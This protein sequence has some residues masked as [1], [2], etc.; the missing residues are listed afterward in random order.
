MMRQLGLL[1]L[2]G[3]GTSGEPIKGDISYTYGSDS[4]KFS[5][6]TA[7]QDQNVPG[8]MLVQIGTDHVDC[9][10]YLDNFF[11][12][13]NPEGTFVFFSVDKVTPGTHATANVNV[14]K[15]SGS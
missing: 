8:Q 15:S 4:A 10:T 3:C 14:M 9:G 2:I 6:G 11:S 5:V 12:F 1:L 7:V 13:N